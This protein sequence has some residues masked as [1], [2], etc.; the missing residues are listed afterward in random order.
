MALQN[1]IIALRKRHN[2]SQEELAEQL[3]VT[4]QAVSRWEN[5]ETTPSIDTLKALVEKFQVSAGDLLGLTEAPI[6]QSCAMPL[7]SLD[8]FGTNADATPN[9]QYC[10]HCFANGAF[11]HDRSLEDMVEANLEFL[12]EFNAGNNTHYSKDEA[13]TVLKAH[14]A[15]L[16]RWQTN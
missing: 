10:S 7:Q 8:D 11:T 4:R 9:T 13:R 12:D 1:V 3:F 15:T 6:C 14:L 2:L 5:G 16:A